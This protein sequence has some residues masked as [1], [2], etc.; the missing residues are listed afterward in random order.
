M[1]KPKLEVWMSESMATMPEA[2]QE[3]TKEY[4]MTETSCYDTKEISP[5]SNIRQELPPTSEF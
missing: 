2:T 5:L 3:K 1:H 4:T